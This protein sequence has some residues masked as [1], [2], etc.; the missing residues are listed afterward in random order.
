MG[1]KL[2]KRKRADLAAEIAKALEVIDDN[3][4][5]PTSIT[6]KYAYS[7]GEPPANISRLESFAIGLHLDVV[8]EY[9]Q[10]VF[11]FGRKP[12]TSGRNHE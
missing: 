10:L 4:V 9:G 11:H 6:V 5:A 8:H 7:R 12:L 1:S 3:E 2:S